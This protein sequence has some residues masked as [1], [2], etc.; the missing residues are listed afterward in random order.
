ME[1][2]DEFRHTGAT[3]DMENLLI[4]PKKSKGKHKAIEIKSDNNDDD[5]NNDDNN[6]D[7]DS[8]SLE[9]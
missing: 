7:D 1:I 5:D 3:Q 6:N 8:E 4:E 9:F 2:E